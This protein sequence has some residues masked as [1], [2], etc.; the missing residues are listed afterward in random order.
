MSRE[1]K[2]QSCQPV[3][4]LIKP[5]T[6]TLTVKHPTFLLIAA[7]TL[8]WLGT[9]YSQAAAPTNAPVAMRTILRG[10]TVTVPVSRGIQQVVLEQRSGSGWRPM[11]V[12]HPRLNQREM[13]KN[14]TFTLPA[15]E[16]GAGIRVQGFRAQK[17]PA[18]FTSGQRVF[19]RADSS[20]SGNVINLGG[21]LT[22]DRNLGGVS[23][24]SL[25]STA[26]TVNAVNSGAGATTQPAA[27]ESDIWQ[28]VGSQLFF[29]NQYRGLQV[30]DLTDP[31][32]PVRTGTLRMAASGDQMFVLDAT[33]TRLALLGRSNSKER[34]GA[35]IFLLHVLD[36][37]PTLTGE[38]P[39]DGAITDSRLIGTT[40]HVLCSTWSQPAPAQSWTSAAVLTS[41]DLAAPETPQTL[42]SLTF[43]GY[44]PVLQAA[45]GHLLI[46]INDA[47]TSR[48]H[49]VDAAAAPLLV[50]S[51]TTRGGLQDKFKI[52]ISNGAIVAVSLVWQNWS[53]RETWVET[54]PLAG[55]DTA[56]LAALELIGARNE[57]LHG[58]RFDGDRLYVVTFRNVDPL[59]IVDLSDPAAPLLTGVLEV[60]GWSTYLEPLGDR[61]LAV[62][63]ED[64]RVTV[65]L[66]DVAD[67]AAP[68]LLARLPLGP[69]DSYSWSEANYDEKAV[70]YLPD[71]GVV[72]VPFESWSWSG[73]GPQK[74]IQAIQVGTDTLTALATISHDFNPRR[75]GWIAGHYVSIS[76]QQLLVHTADAAASGTPT[77]ALSLAWRTD[78]V[79][80]FGDYL[81]QVEDGDSGWYGGPF[82]SLAYSARTASTV[83]RITPAS[84][85]DD[86]LE[87]VDLGPGRIVGITRQGDRVYAAQW[88]RA[89]GTEPQ[90][91]RTW[92]LDLS[93]PPVVQQVTTV[94]HDL[95]GLSEW[96]LQLGSVQPLWTDAQTLVWFIPAQQQNWWW[97]DRPIYIGSPVMTIQP[98]RIQPVLGI[99]TGTVILTG[100]ASLTLRTTAS[101]K[102]TIPS[103]ITSLAAVLCQIDVDAVSVTATT[104]QAVRVNGSVRGT[105]SAFAGGGFVFFSY[106]IALQKPAPPSAPTPVSGRGLPVLTTAVIPLRPTISRLGSWLQVVDFRAADP[107]LRSPVSIPGQLLSIAQVDA[108]GA[109]VLTNSDMALRSGAPATRVLQ[110]SAYD[111]VSAWQ[112]DSYITATPWH[113]ASTTDGTRIYLVRETSGPGVV[114]VGYNSTTGRLGQLSAWTTAALPSLLHVTTGH[115]LASSYGNLEVA[116]ISPTGAL[117]PAAAFDTPTN[118]WLQIQRAVFTPLLDLWIPA[119]DYGVEFLQHNAL[120]P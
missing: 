3:R 56:P 89:T 38:V 96:E 99:T 10:R 107:V 27:V 76:G 12:A 73:P 102:S 8:V 77:M 108:Q 46:G 42:G 39:L 26:L 11:A 117:T 36:G 80:P 54:F 120:A 84:D 68:A 19:D 18:R 87:E 43:P 88:L 97:W 82:L 118:L 94:E 45:E 100:N 32:Q 78:R 79:L 61:L 98:I 44:N 7:A 47:G 59:F 75:G 29:F 6:P 72:M 85:P 95:S 106:D 90:R 69:E 109:L 63:V 62:G 17:F 81:V 112:L 114:A 70:E 14:V 21:V 25:S 37:V 101:E 35:T 105:S 64:R 74:G 60:P 65:S 113:T 91:L 40:L 67:A 86:L 66:F 71:Q 50:K 116:S 51:V 9:I 103:A 110:A 49:V 53:S 104:P 30:F 16:T 33:G 24:P 2:I 34:P 28:I 22:L 58:T 5:T 119:G 48:L 111:G 55:T 4:N 15:G 52:S 83:L 41:V 13:M 115:L 1:P 23:I 92:V 57:T 31:T 20:G 93:G